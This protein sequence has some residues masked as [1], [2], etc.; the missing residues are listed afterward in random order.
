MRAS[1]A[2]PQILQWYADHPGATSVEAGAALG[3]HPVSVRRALSKARR[4]GL[5]PPELQ[6]HVCT[7]GD[8][9]PLRGVMG[10]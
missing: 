10:S 8:V 9:H 3:L 5:V 2:L 6:V 4:E 1:S 7:C